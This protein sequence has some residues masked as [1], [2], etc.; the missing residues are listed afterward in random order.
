MSRRGAGVPAEA[1]HRVVLL[2]ERWHALSR[3]TDRRRETA[4]GSGHAG[5]L[6][7]QLILNCKM[8]KGAEMAD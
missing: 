8:E 6:I 2:Q 3:G 7:M 1:R 4:F 5:R